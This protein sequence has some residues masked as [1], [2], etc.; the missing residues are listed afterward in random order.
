M[1]GFPVKTAFFLFGFAVGAAGL[2]LYQQMLLQSPNPTEEAMALVRIGE[3]S[4]AIS[5]LQGHLKALPSD[6]TARLQYGFLLRDAGQEEKAL[7]VFEG[8]YT[9]VSD[10]AK[11]YDI[12]RNLFKIYSELANASRDSAKVCVSGGHFGAA[13]KMFEKEIRHQGEAAKW[14]ALT[15]WGYEWAK[16]LWTYDYVENLK[17]V[18]FTYW[19]EGAEGE[20]IAFA[21][22]Y[23]YNDW[24]QYSVDSLRSRV[25][26]DFASELFKR[27]GAIYEKEKYAEAR[28][29]WTAAVRCMNLANHEVTHPNLLAA[30]Y[31]MA[32]CY[33]NEGMNASGRALLAEVEKLSPGYG[34]ARGMIASSAR[35]D[36]YGRANSHSKRAD[37]YFEKKAW[38]LA[39]ASF[40]NA[41]DVLIQFGIEQGDEEICRLRYNIAVCFANEGEYRRAIST[42]FEIRGA[43]PKYKPDLIDEQE[44]SWYKAWKL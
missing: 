33:I 5:L 41:I 32:L 16:T 34:G 43:N 10:S 35:S 3:R 6:T 25:L 44:A 38:A 23:H 31:N 29:T 2:L 1:S 26:S 22:A 42:L 12:A 4:Q 17:N 37:Q 11:R 28:K 8:L 7:V 19:D 9:D 24:L 36:A 14:N 39:R 27:A 18:A 20:A 21:S 15:E 13:R 30:K 40:R